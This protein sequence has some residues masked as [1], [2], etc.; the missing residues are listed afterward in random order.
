MSDVALADRRN[1]IVVVTG[2]KGSG[3]S[4]LLARHVAPQF[5]RVVM[6]D[7]TGEGRELYPDAREAYGLRG[8]LDAMQGFHEG[9]VPEWRITAI[10]DPS[11][12]ADLCNL[13][14]PRY[15]GKTVP[16]SAAVGGVAIECHEMQLI[17]P[18]SGA[19]RTAEI[20][21]V[22]ARSRH[23]R[24]SW[25][26]AARRPAELSKFLTSQSDAFYAFRTHE[27]RDVKWLSDV[28]SDFAATVRELPEY[29][30]AHYDTMT[31]AVEVLGPSYQPIKGTGKR[32]RRS[33]QGGC[34]DAEG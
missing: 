4:T 25:L 24:L 32:R 16:L 21:D 23:A 26:C 31:A 2:R 28:S 20:V 13:L 3:K 15:D 9:D 34:D 1:A 7:W 19:G 22:M 12:V 14:V 10:L 8:V 6:V 29:H 17:T 11:Q 30:S 27:P 5:P 33:A 18:V